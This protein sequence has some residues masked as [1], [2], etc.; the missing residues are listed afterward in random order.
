[1]AGW[2]GS[3]SET[4]FFAWGN[5]NS[6]QAATTIRCRAADS[7]R[8]GRLFL[9]VD[10]EGNRLGGGIGTG[11]PHCAP[12]PDSAE[13]LRGAGTPHGRTTPHGGTA[14]HGRLASYK[15]IAAPNSARA[16][17]R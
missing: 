8:A 10:H 4:L 3:L 12:T 7:S 16:P 17:H 13:P 6:P 2:I 1:M 15:D 11:P 14:P 5:L 9:S